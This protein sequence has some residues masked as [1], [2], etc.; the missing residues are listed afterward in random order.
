MIGIFSLVVAIGKCHKFSKVIDKYQIFPYRRIRISELTK[1]R[2]KRLNRR[3]EK[4][5]TGNRNITGCQQNQ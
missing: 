1:V 3:D 4:Q 5:Q 2:I